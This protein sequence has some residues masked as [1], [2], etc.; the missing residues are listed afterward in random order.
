MRAMSGNLLNGITSMTIHKIVSMTS[1]VIVLL[2]VEHFLC[3]PIGTGSH[4]ARN[5]SL[6]G[7]TALSSQ[8]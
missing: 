4:F 7:R 3:R 8:P 2:V 1:C 5:R 6:D